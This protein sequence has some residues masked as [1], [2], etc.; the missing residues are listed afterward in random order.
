M[1]LTIFDLDNTLLA[2]DSDYTWGNFLIAKGIVDAEDYQQKNDQFYA[3]YQQKKLDIQA[4]QRFVLTPTIP[5]T[6][7]ECRELHDEF[8]RDYIE[9]IRL[10]KAE[11]LIEQHK[12][13]GDTLLVITATN[14]FIA[15]PIVSMLAIEHILATDPEWIDGHFTGNIV[16]TPCF[17]EGKIARLNIWLEEQKQQNGSI[18]THTT[19]YSDSINDAPLLD[20]VD[21]AIAVDPDD[22]LRALANDKQWEIMSLRD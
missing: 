9:P 15:S 19:F 14:H 4:Y 10:P 11:Q 18:F 6:T 8:M 16:G 17:Q 13:Q 5:M 7:A 21:T 12:Q 20:I 3:D 22:A 1:K 2:G